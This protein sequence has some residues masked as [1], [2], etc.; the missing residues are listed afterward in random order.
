M[1]REHVQARMLV[2]EASNLCSAFLPLIPA[3]GCDQHGLPWLHSYWRQA[4]PRL[5]SQADANDA[6]LH[7]S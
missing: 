3:C 7:G 4:G 5:S 1:Y 2:L 6:G